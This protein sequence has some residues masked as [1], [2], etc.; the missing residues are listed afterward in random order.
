ME[1]ADRVLDLPS[2]KSALAAVRAVSEIDI[3]EFDCAVIAAVLATTPGNSVSEKDL[4]VILVEFRRVMAE[5]TVLS[6]LLSGA[7]QVYVDGDGKVGVRGHDGGEGEMMR[8]L[9]RSGIATVEEKTPP[10]CQSDQEAL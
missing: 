3:D 1:D 6:F 9:L 10:S 5:C 7:I 8:Q 4:E 2:V